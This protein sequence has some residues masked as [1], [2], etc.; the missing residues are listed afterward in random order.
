MLRVEGL[1]KRYGERTVV[2]GVSFTV[3]PGEVVAFLGPNGAGKTT[4]LRMIA[5]YLEPDAGSAQIAGLDAHGQ[6]RQAQAKLGF[7]PEGAPAWPDMTPRGFLAFHGQARGFKGEALKQRIDRAAGQVGLGEALDQPIETLSKGFKRRT[8]LASA[9]LHEPE[10]LILDEPTDGL[11][12]NQKD[13][14]R[15]LIRSL[16]ENTA[17]LISTHL[18]DEVQ[19]MC[20]RAIV[21]H[22]GEIV[23]DATPPA[24]AARAA[25]GRLEDAF[26]DLTRGEA[27]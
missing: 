3:S 13:G 26:R 2:R 19:A 1:E 10:A 8:G 11:D 17:I 4:T 27:A 22:Q 14:V 25:S 7:L 16:R 15:A 18:L 6:R 23:A 5:G 9:V 20:D 12:P 21:I 24:L